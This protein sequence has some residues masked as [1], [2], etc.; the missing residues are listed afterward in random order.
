VSYLSKKAKAN[1]GK[2][3][4]KNVSNV[5]L[6]G[7]CLVVLLTGMFAARLVF[8]FPFPFLTS[9]AQPAPEGVAVTISLLAF[10]KDN[11][12]EVLAVKEY[13]LSQLTLL[14]TSGKEIK[15]FAI[16]CLFLAGPPKDEI[17][18]NIDLTYEIAMT[19]SKGAL[20]SVTKTVRLPIVANLALHQSPIIPITAEQLGLGK[21]GDAT[22][23]TTSVNV[24]ADMTT[25]GGRKVF[26]SSGAVETRLAYQE[27]GFFSSSGI[28]GQVSEKGAGTLVAVL[29]GTWKKPEWRAVSVVGIMDPK[30]GVTAYMIAQPGESSIDVTGV[31]PTPGTTVPTTTVNPIAVAPGQA[32]P[33]FIP[34]QTTSP[35]TVTI[36]YDISNPDKPPVDS[37]KPY[38]SPV[39]ESPGEPVVTIPPGGSITVSFPDNTVFISGERD[40][41][42]SGVEA[43][44]GGGDYYHGDPYQF[45]M[46]PVSWAPLIG[47]INGYRMLWPI[48]IFGRTIDL[49]FIFAVLFSVVLVILGA[50]L[51]KKKK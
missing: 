13:R 40:P 38:T 45:S 10:C 3:K 34:K 1:A 15:Y 32:G 11:T 14:T 24:E 49:A 30:T 19:T 2:D 9:N 29:T 6:A 36:P 25:D 41:G 21:V 50:A 20:E 42:G 4:K 51:S 8:N 23:L 12:T 44:S 28:Q 18:Q 31:P 46:L 16:T 27:A 43:P 33:I 26:T 35:S 7:A 5:L 37:V 47:L 48:Y 39:S 22:L 17:L